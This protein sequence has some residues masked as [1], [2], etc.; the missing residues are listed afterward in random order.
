VGLLR[1]VWLRRRLLLLLGPPA[2]LLRRRPGCP[3]PPCT[4]L[5]LLV[6]LLCAGLRRELRAGLRLP[7][8]LLLRLW[9]LPLLLLRRRRR[10]APLLRWMLGAA[11]AARDKSK[12]RTNSLG[13]ELRSPLPRRAE[14]GHALADVTTVGSHKG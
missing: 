7:S 3:S 14:A 10:P 5:R 2:P 8:R 13:R 12:H 9:L 1:L 6:R 4:S 11:A